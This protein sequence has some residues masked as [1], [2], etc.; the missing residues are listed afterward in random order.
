MRID[1]FSHYPETEGCDVTVGIDPGSDASTI[2]NE[3]F[4]KMYNDLQKGEFHP[5]GECDAEKKED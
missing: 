1:R 4:S 5:V 3:L 2:Y